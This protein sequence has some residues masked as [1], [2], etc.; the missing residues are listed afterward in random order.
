MNIGSSDHLA[1][2]NFTIP[3]VQNIVKSCEPKNPARKYRDQFCAYS[4]QSGS[5][6]GD[7]GSPF[8]CDENGYAVL[9]G[10]H[11]GHWKFSAD[12][13]S[14]IESFVFKHMEFIKMYMSVNPGPCC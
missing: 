13:G 5:A 10:I 3:V 6:S 7:S 4:E 9:H 12:K 8:I 14:V 2:A 11:R 1:V